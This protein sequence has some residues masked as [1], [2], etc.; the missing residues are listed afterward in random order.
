MRLPGVARLVRAVVRRWLGALVDLDDVTFAL[1]AGS[2]D[3][4]NVELRR[5]VLEQW[6]GPGVVA[7]TVQRV[8]V[9]LPL[10]W[11]RGARVRLSV[12][13]LGLVIDATAQHKPSTAADDKGAALDAD[14]ARYAEAV[15]GGHRR[16]RLDAAAGSAAAAGSSPGSAASRAAGVLPPPV[17]RPG[18]LARLLRRISRRIAES[19]EVRVDGAAVQIKL[20][21]GADF[22]VGFSQF[23]IDTVID[24]VEKEETILDAGALRKWAKAAKLDG[25]YAYQTEAT[26][27][28]GRETSKPGAAALHEAGPS[29]AAADAS[30]YGGLAAAAAAALA[31]CGCAVLPPS[32]CCGTVS[33]AVDAAESAT[34]ACSAETDGDW[35]CNISARQLANLAGAIL[36]EHAGASPGAGASTSRA[37]PDTDDRGLKL[38]APRRPPEPGEAARAWWRYAAAGALGRSDSRLARREFAASRRCYLVLCA[39]RHRAAATRDTRGDAPRDL[40]QASGSAAALGGDDGP[41]RHDAGE[42]GGDAA[43]RAEMWF[44]EAC[45]PSRYLVLFRHLAV[46]RHAKSAPG[47]APPALLAR[48]WSL[49][50]PSIA[51]GPSAFA[52]VVPLISAATT[53]RVVV[54]LRGALFASLR[55]AHDAP[56]AALGAAV[57]AECAVSV[58]GDG[59]DVAAFDVSAKW[60][61]VLFDDDAARAHHGGGW[62][63]RK[64]WMRVVQEGQSGGEPRDGDEE[65]ES[66]IPVEAPP[67]GDAIVVRAAWSR[68]AGCSVAVDADG[69]EFVAAWVL[70]ARLLGAVHHVTQ[71]ISDTRA[72]PADTARASPAAAARLVASFKLD[73]LKLTARKCGLV[74]P[75]CWRKDRGAGVLA[76]EKAVIEL[77]Q[78]DT[79]KPHNVRYDLPGDVDGAKV[80]DGVILRCED[81]SLRER[82][83]NDL[84][85]DVPNDLREDGF[86]ESVLEPCPVALRVGVRGGLHEGI[87]ARHVVVLVDIQETEVFASGL[88]LSRLL[89]CLG[90]YLA[91]HALDA[92]GIVVEDGSEAPQTRILCVDFRL[93]I[94]NVKLAVFDD[95]RSAMQRMLVALHDVQMSSRH[96][97]GGGE[98]QLVQKYAWGDVRVALA[99]AT[100]AAG[101]KVVIV[102]RCGGAFDYSQKWPATLE[103]RPPTTSW[104]GPG[105]KMMWESLGGL[106]SD[107]AEQAADGLKR[108]VLRQALVKASVDDAL[109]AGKLAFALLA[110][111]GSHAAAWSSRERPPADAR[112]PRKKRP[113]KKM[114][115]LL[116]DGAP[117]E[118]YHSRVLS[119]L[120]YDV[121]AF[122]VVLVSHGPRR[123]LLRIRGDASYQTDSDNAGAH[124][125]F[126]RCWNCRLD[127]YRVVTAQWENFIERGAELRCA[128]VS[129]NNAKERYLVEAPNDVEVNASRD[130]LAALTTLLS[131]VSRHASWTVDVSAGAAAAGKRAASRPPA[132]H[133]AA[134][135][136]RNKTGCTLHVELFGTDGEP[137]KDRDLKIADGE[138]MPLP[139]AAA[140]ALV[141]A[142]ADGRK[143]RVCRPLATNRAQHVIAQTSEGT[144]DFTQPSPRRST[145]QRRVRASKAQAGGAAI[146]WQ[147]KFD[148]RGA[149]K[150]DCCAALR[151]RNAS[152]V[153]LDVGCGDS[154]PTVSRRVL[155]GSPDA[156]T[157]TQ[158]PLHVAALSGKGV[159]VGNERLRADEGSKWRLVKLKNDHLVCARLQPHRSLDALVSGTTTA[160]DV[161]IEAPLVIRNALPMRLEVRIL[162]LCENVDGPSKRRIVVKKCTLEPG[163][164]LG[165][166]EADVRS[167]VWVALRCCAYGQAWDCIKLNAKSW[168]RKV[169]AAALVGSARPPTRRKTVALASRRCRFAVDVD[170]RY[171]VFSGRTL[172]ESSLLDLFEG[173]EAL[174]AVPTY[175]LDVVVRAPCVVIDRSGLRG[176]SFATSRTEASETRRHKS[177]VDH[178]SSVDR[179]DA[180]VATPPRISGEAPESRV[181][182]EALP[183]NEAIWCDVD[184][185]LGSVRRPRAK[186]RFVVFG[187]EDAL[188]APRKASLI[189]SPLLLEWTNLSPSLLRGNVLALEYSEGVS[190]RFRSPDR[191]TSASEPLTLRPRRDSRIVV[192]FLQDTRPAWLDPRLMLARRHTLCAVDCVSRDSIEFFVAECV[193]A[194]GDSV[195][196]GGGSEPYAVFVAAADFDDA[197]ESDDEA[198]GEDYDSAASEVGTSDDDEQ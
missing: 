145:M 142:E 134:T 154:G 66:S 126:G 133:L 183:A 110:G 38:C 75:Y 164:A 51:D 141:S 64:R 105:G 153:S 148:E 26:R 102:E 174:L 197:D 121:S 172:S 7:A 24:T 168:R 113:Q 101:P 86:E 118:A 62:A 140:M 100:P 195:D 71:R 129:N 23:V 171:E 69:L 70:F 186:A 36:D 90:G 30:L 50:E 46:L 108:L 93:G 136:L 45:W 88:R 11:R 116:V 84:R 72:P 176:L 117:V 56:L 107:S 57:V 3:V 190:S 55:D 47:L 156:P 19:V 9:S 157:V 130:A 189:S 85:E 96:F 95:D 143:W 194:A 40:A 122:D 196:V 125:R 15:R 138:M 127:V 73:S 83:P 147:C 61:R 146:V 91:L 10:S 65:S 104:L 163:R 170:A 135:T 124:E 109:V 31:T 114:S 14:E 191:K 87:E 82:L 77:A 119:R 6:L 81:F 152:G 187:D 120:A 98:G 79:F 59:D 32:G 185:C 17:S 112:S 149:L 159:F 180:A 161:N 89:S 158:L 1:W 166:C 178:R 18:F 99:A 103:V 43:A 37:R 137:L 39:R 123:P 169:R 35:H 167:Y 4:V 29:R 132:V 21:D 60:R 5:A 111:L 53:I 165:V 28:N 139:A 94:E 182:E 49:E 97:D 13:G 20:V 115:N 160:A 2:V 144:P 41:W 131:Q 179:S 33:L 80:Y 184:V 106:K 193:V 68:V 177:S 67:R 162:V 181:G 76:V 74:V 16:P 52:A 128:S 198:S 92:N 192:A 8:G 150:I 25:L 58:D 44:I 22:G 54:Q 151:C 12:V 63:A 175:A 42:A 78:F 155:A 173:P 188:D 48:S 27:R 34:L